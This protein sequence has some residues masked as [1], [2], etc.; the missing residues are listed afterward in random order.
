[1]TREEA[2]RFAAE[3]VEKM[4]NNPE[5]NNRGYKV[6]DWKTPTIAERASAIVQIAEVLIGPQSALHQPSTLEAPESD[7]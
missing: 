7:E 6:D 4:G 2:V 5:L 1:M 3:L